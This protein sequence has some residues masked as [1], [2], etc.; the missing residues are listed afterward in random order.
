[1]D[2][3]KEFAAT[4]KAGRE[5]KMPIGAVDAENVAGKLQSFGSSFF[6]SVSNAASNAASSGK[7]AFVD[8]EAGLPEDARNVLGKAT[9]GVTAASEA[10]KTKA[11]AAQESMLS[12]E[13]I[14]N[15]SIAF[16]LGAIFISGSFF[17][18]P[19]IVFAPQKFSLLFT[20]GSISIVSGVIIL[21]DTWTFIK[22]M[23][24]KDKFVYT[25]T[26]FGS[27]IGTLYASLG[28]RSYFLTLFFGIAQVI[29][30]VNFVISFVPGGTTMLNMIW[31]FISG[32]GKMFCKLINR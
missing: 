13:Q 17:F 6:S 23:C 8:L 19:M 16:V 32:A 30:L 18:L 11:A 4:A 10:A 28:M 5:Q 27:M 2:A 31:K 15:A 12:P 7:Q 25:F 9:A 22:S 3:L 20:L 21:R 26:Y 14:R 29:C 24:T 1:M